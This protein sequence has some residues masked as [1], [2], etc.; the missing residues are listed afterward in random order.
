MGA[1]TER[2]YDRRAVA[3]NGGSLD[4]TEADTA[5]GALERFGRRPGW[6]SDAAVGPQGL[7]SR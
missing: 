3:I 6:M 7:S 1:H 5:S 2:R 4:R